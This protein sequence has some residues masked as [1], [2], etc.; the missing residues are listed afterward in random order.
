M[1]FTQSYSKYLELYYQR[2][3]ID[4]FSDFRMH[5]WFIDRYLD[6]NTP[7]DHT[8]PSSPYFIIIEDIDDTMSADLIMKNFKSREDV[9]NVY[10]TQKGS[11]GNYKRDVY[12][13]I[14]QDEDQKRVIEAL[15][16]KTSYLDI[17]DK[18]I[19][20]VYNVSIEDARA[21]FQS[22]CFLSKKSP[23][24]TLDSF[25]SGNNP[26]ISDDR[27]A[28]LYVHALR[29]IFRYCT[30]CSKQ[31]DNYVSMIRQCSEHS[32]NDYC[33][34]NI[35]IAAIFKDFS[36]ITYIDEDLEVERHIIRTPEATFRCKNCS[37]LFNSFEYIKQHLYSRHPELIQD[38]KSK[39]ENFKKFID[40]IDF[41]ILETVE[42]TSEKEPPSF[43]R[44]RKNPN[45]VVYDFPKLFSGDIKY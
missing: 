38:T 22:L 17:S 18:H 45:I 44:S 28:E 34:R 5:Q 41:F 27:I 19:D 15:P 25:V 26:S 31:Y 9:I 39:K 29:K 6:G 37:K 13:N 4:V 11:S 42:G 40:S 12:I 24:E 43:G 33:P 32:L 16:Y 36:G 30:I 7:S 20:E 10:I 35:E 23:D 3:L 21:I 1:L 14:S 8:I 2:R